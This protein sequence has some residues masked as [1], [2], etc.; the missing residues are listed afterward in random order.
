MIKLASRSLYLCITY[1][2][3]SFLCP[4]LS[5]A[6]IFEV[7]ESNSPKIYQ[8]NKFPGGKHIR[9]GVSHNPPIG[10]HGKGGPPKGL[11]IDIIRDVAEKEGWNLAFIEKTW[12]NLLKS[13]DAGEIDLLGGV[14]F[15]PARSKKYEFS[16]EAALSNWGE[17]YRNKNI[18]L[19]GIR[20]LNGKRIA[21]IP[22]GTHSVALQTLSKAFGFDFTAVPAKD[23]EHTLEL[24]DSG[25]ADVGIVSRTHIFFG[26]NHTALAAN[27]QFNPIEVRFAAPK[28]TGKEIFA[29]IDR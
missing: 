2:G 11:V 29:A 15:T 14:A 17:V 27:I 16:N 24:V 19:N 6:A 18:T 5:Y 10:F 25:E 12:P 13:L 28:G 26:D 3:L 9:V 23:Y 7:A 21:L 8:E 4:E 1:F 22:K 20:D